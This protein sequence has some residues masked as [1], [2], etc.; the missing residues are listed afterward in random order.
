MAMLSSAIALFTSL[1]S[2]VGDNG[3]FSE[4]TVYITKALHKRLKVGSAE[5]EMELTDVSEEA[6]AAYLS[7]RMNG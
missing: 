2:S 1:K 6:I 5:L 7:K 3:R 4:L